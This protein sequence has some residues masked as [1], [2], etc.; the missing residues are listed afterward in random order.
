MKN[1]ILFFLFVIFFSKFYSQKIDNNLFGKF[2]STDDKQLYSNFVFDNNGK[3]TIAEFS[4]GDFFIKNDTL[5]VFPD[6]D[7][8]KFIIEKDKI[9]GVS[10]WVKDGI[11]VRSNDAIENNR[12]DDGLAKKNAALLNEY[13]EKTRVK[14]NQMAML[15]DE[16]LLNEYQ[17]TV[18]SLCNRN[19]VRACK[20]W[21]G[22]ETLKQSGGMDT[23][24]SGQKTEIK[25][26]QKLIEIAN[27]VIKIDPAEGH[28]LLGLYYMMN[29][30]TEMG[31]AELNKAAEL[32]SKDAAMTKLNFTMAKEEY[33]SS[34]QE[35]QLN[36]SIVSS[37][38]EPIY[39]STLRYWNEIGFDKFYE[40][41][42]NKFGYKYY[43]KT[44]SD[45]F[46]VRDYLNEHF[47]KLSK[48]MYK[49]E[50]KNLIEFQTKDQNKINLIIE[51][52]NGLKFDKTTEKS[53]NGERYENYKKEEKIGSSSY[54]YFVSILYPSPEMPNE[55]VTV[56]L[57][58]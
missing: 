8:F 17:Q 56:I 50:S 32:G 47:E 1:T 35:N 16:K 55:P 15:F 48:F 10:N 27:K 39:S 21:F 37:E 30:Q 57:Y 29:K 5:I 26:S 36:S 12:K 28:H 58:K 41:I 54:F 18:E 22:T 31:E 46:E 13:Y 25:E 14:N 23:V 52:L 44:V 6:K 43:D 40:D 53:K 24:L 20:E 19:L 7:L 9:K 34:N 49:D 42:K 45:E 51:E 2:V 4:G 38:T 11:W 3:V 33:D